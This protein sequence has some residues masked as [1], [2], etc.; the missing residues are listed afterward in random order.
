MNVLLR[1]DEEGRTISWNK[2]VFVTKLVLA[3]FVFLN[4]V[5]I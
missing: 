5:Y 1:N 3:A 4:A 2:I